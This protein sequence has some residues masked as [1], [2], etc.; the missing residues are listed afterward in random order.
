MLGARMV[1]NGTNLLSELRRVFGPAWLVMMA[2]VDAASIITAMQ[3]GAEFK[4]G[5]VLVLLLLILPL[6]FIQEVAGRVGAVTGKGLGELIRE[7]FSRRTAALMS[8]PMAITDLLSYVA[9][10]A[11]IAIAASILGIS[12]LIAIPVVYVAHILFVYRRDHGA[13]ERTLLVM[14]MLMLVA[15]MGLMGDGIGSYPLMPTGI[16]SR[17]FYLLAANVGAVIMPFMLFYQTTATAKKK[18]RSVRATK[19]E[20]FT[21]AVFGEIIMIAI[22]MVSS[23]LGHGAGFSTM[24]GIAEGIRGIGGTYAPVIFSAGLVLAGFLALVVI[25]MAS[26]WG[27]TEALNMKRD[28]WFKIYVLESLPAALVPLLFTNLISLVIG[29][30]VLLVFVL[31]GPVVTLGILAQRE[32]IMGRH[33]LGRFDRIAFWGSAVAILLCGIAALL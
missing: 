9:E 17:F 25:S 32:N 16:G 2:D 8:L 19:I 20:T 29:L 6:Y 18:F 15:Y 27:V 26:A 5:F 28:T 13:I 4:Y 1:R 33:R 22:V 30:M 12:P 21:G 24:Q 23:G 7:N 11:G 3:S 31:I 10:Y 14:S